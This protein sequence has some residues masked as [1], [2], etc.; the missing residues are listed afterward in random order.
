MGNSTLREKF[1][2]Y[3]KEFASIKKIQILGECLKARL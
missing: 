1:N 3:F 2:F